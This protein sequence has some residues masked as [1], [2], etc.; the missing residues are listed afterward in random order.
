MGKKIWYFGIT[1]L[2]ERFVT[3]THFI[4]FTSMAVSYRIVNCD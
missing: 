1:I 3:I 4:L 2:I